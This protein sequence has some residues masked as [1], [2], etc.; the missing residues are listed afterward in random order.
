MM[1]ATLLAEIESNNSRNNLLTTQS[2]Q[3]SFLY[4]GRTQ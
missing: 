4:D 3:I 1:F 2:L